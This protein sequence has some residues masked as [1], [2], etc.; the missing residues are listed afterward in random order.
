LKIKF[1]NIF[2]LFLFTSIAH[3]DYNYRAD[4]LLQIKYYKLSI[5]I[6]ENRIMEN[7]NSLG[8]FR[9]K[10]KGY[11][12]K[13]KA[14]AEIIEGISDPKES[15]ND[16]IKQESEIINQRDKI[17][18][19]KTEFSKKIIWLYKYGSDYTV[20]LL[21]TSGSLNDFYARLRYLNKLSSMR[22]NQF[23][24]IKSE[25]YIFSEKKKLSSF[26]KEELRRYIKTNKEDQQIL[27]AEKLS[28]EDSVR[29][30]QS[31]IESNQRQ[32][33]RIKQLTETVEEKLNGLN[34]ESEYKTNDIPD[35]G[36]KPFPS[37]KG[38]LIMPVQSV[39]IILDYGKSTSAETGAI[40]FNNGVDVSVAL[41]S[42]VKSVASGIIEKIFFS[43]GF[44]NVVIIKHDD[45]FRTV[46]A[47]LRNI[48]VSEGDNVV[49]GQL[50]AETDE[51]LNGQSFHFEIW[52]DNYTFDPKLWVRRGVSVYN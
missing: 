21:F 33:Q 30:Y 29:Y 12:E 11:E 41:G 9:S 38:M 50:I 16:L 4:K 23:R 43:P 8:I 26:G 32:A 47:I 14:L 42:P 3:A 15:K 19:L 37:L 6:L 51:N 44:G 22:K 25:E 27:L 36:N 48:S 13:I 5:E 46:Y 34:T 10:L 24:A 1:L 35:Y 39:D 31:L 18:K 49:P 20:Q 28:A 45:S 2:L 17:E 40:L 7:T 52:K